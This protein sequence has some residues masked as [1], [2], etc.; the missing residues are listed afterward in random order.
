MIEY[1]CIFFFQSEDLKKF[2]EKNLFVNL[3]KIEN[4]DSHTIYKSFNG[5]STFINCKN[6]GQ[7]KFLSTSLVFQFSLINESHGKQFLLRKEANYPNYR[8]K[9]VVLSIPFDR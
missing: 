8:A 2:I 4:S 9:I 1:L 6:V 7:Y 5:M 3:K